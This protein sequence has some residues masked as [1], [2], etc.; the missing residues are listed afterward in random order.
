MARLD[1]LDGDRE[2]AQLAAVLGREFSYELLLAVASLNEGVLQEELAK[3]VEAEILYQKG[4]P[5]QC[6]YTFK[7]ALLEDAL[8]NSLIKSSRRSF[9]RELAKCWKHRFPKRARL[10]R[11]YLPT[12][13][14]RRA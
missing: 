1:R 14:R 13:T 5:P 3:L 12:I 11:N 8:Y 2:L 6:T 4:R 10:D 9:I 7:H